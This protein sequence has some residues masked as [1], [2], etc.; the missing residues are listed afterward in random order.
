MI[1]IQ[2]G[3]Q[4]ALG[5][6]LGVAVA[7][8]IQAQGA[9]ADLRPCESSSVQ[10]SPCRTLF[11]RAPVLVG[12][13][14]A[15]GSGERRT[16]RVWVF[17]TETGSVTATQIAQSAGL[18]FDI[19]AVG[20]AKQLRFTPA[21]LA[22][23]PVPVW[24]IV[25][26]TTAAAPEPCSSMAVPVSAGFAVFTDSERLERVELGTLYRFRERGSGLPF[27]I[28]IYPESAWPSIEA[29]V[30]DFLPSLRVLQDRGE[31]SSY[32]VID[33]RKVNVRVRSVRLGRE[34]T[35]QGDAVRVRLR[36]PAG[37]ELTS[38]F[39]VFPQEQKY[40]KVR[41]TYPPDRH[42]QPLIDDFVK[43]VLEARA[44]EPAHCPP[45]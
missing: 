38:Y 13:P 28:F 14:S 7:R 31:V 32:E 23:H 21:Q 6:L 12:L 19:A 33:R 36:G 5:L 45:L 17:V 3:N 11:D 39:A 25:P 41:V 1:R 27:D 44:A 9:A 26:I 10:S 42:V 34:I 24:F 40:L 35:L 15:P 4:I 30:D 18:D 22:D 37:N 43:Q 8:P 20:I 2:T 29:Q 16:A